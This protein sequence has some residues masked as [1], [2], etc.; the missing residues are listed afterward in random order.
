MCLS[1]RVL[2]VGKYVPLWEGVVGRQL[3]AIQVGIGG[4]QLCAFQ[5][6][7]WS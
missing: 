7:G 1:V 2:V 6:G 3:C 4:R 5:V